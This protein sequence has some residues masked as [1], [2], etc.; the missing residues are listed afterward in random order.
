MP[1]E[2]LDAIAADAAFT[3]DMIYVFWLRAARGLLRQAVLR[4]A[5]DGP[6]RGRARKIAVAL[7]LPRVRGRAPLG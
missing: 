7:P 2:V 4:G 1:D 3:K 5:G 6:G